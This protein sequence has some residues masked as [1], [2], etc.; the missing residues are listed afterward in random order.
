VARA[1]FVHRYLAVHGQV[2]RLWCAR[3]AGADHGREV[4]HP[5]TAQVPERAH[6]RSRRGVGRSSGLSG[7]RWRN[8]LDL[9]AHA[10]RRCTVR[11]SIPTATPSMGQ[12]SSGSLTPLSGVAARRGGEVWARWL[13]SESVW[14]RRFHRGAGERRRHRCRGRG[15]GGG[16]SHSHLAS[17]HRRCLFL[18]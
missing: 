7:P 12:R 14:P 15:G 11:R 1:A 8:H 9:P 2:I 4:D 16:L 6:A 3:R 18:T 17:G 13:S 5:P 10:M